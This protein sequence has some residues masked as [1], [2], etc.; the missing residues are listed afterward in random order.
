MTPIRNFFLIKKPL[1][2][3]GCQANDR[4]INNR[5][6][7]EGTEPYFFWKKAGTS[8]P[9]LTRKYFAFLSLRILKIS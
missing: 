2:M 7:S 9:L 3:P 6:I 1:P 4:K 8:L 5:K